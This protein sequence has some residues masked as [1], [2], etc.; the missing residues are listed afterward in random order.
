MMKY[1]NRELKG[2]YGYIRKQTYFEIVKTFILFAMALGIFFIGYATLHTRKSL[3]SVLA[4]LALLPACRSLVGVIMLARFRSLSSSEH[5]EYIKHTGDRG[6]LFENIITTSERSFFI[7]VILCSDHNVICL[8][9]GKQDE[10]AAL[11]KHMD[12]VMKKAGHNVTFKIF[13]NKEA[14][15]ERAAVLGSKEIGSITA[16]VM[17]TI[18]AVSL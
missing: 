16:G 12:N 4:V 6:V 5:D 9:G 14:F 3:W 7:P 15:T 17:E 8:Y 10:A 2:T 13:D 11:K 18:K 1:I